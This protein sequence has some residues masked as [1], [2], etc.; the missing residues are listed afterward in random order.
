[1]NTDKIEY[2][3]SIAADPNN[4]EWLKLL[5]EV[6]QE[7][8]CLSCNPYY[9]TAYRSSELFY[10]THIPK[11]MFE[12]KKKGTQFNT[13]LDIGCAYGTLA[14]YAKKLF[15]VQQLYA[16]DF[17][18]YISDELVDMYQFNY[19]IN[20][21]ERDQFPWNIKYDLIIF[22]EV[23]E[24]LNFNGLFTLKKIHSLLSDKGSVYLSTPDALYWGRVTKYYV[25]YNDIP[26]PIPN[27]PVIDDHVY[28]YNLYEIF[29]LITK[30]GF[31]IDILDYAP[32]WAARHFN[33]KL[34]KS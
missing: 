4:S 1:M 11:W 31:K 26:Y 33:I 25:D 5:I 20:N 14:L 16:I 29:D 32:G 9:K 22:T 18:K 7:I 12:E 30:A 19:L 3:N 13:I 2:I 10:W 24:H 17:M 21:F 28:Q 15:N 27:A 8:E 6:Q 34:V 23:F